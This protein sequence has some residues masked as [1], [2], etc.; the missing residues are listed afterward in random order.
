MGRWFT[1]GLS[2][3]TLYPDAEDVPAFRE[4]VR[5]AEALQSAGPVTEEARREWLVRAAERRATRWHG[6]YELAPST[7]VLHF[8]YDS[9]GREPGAR[10]LAAEL[11]RLARGFVKEPVG[12]RD[13]S[14]DA[15]ALRGSR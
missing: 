13:P 6:L 8:F 15:R 9:S 14:H 7:D 11:G 4:L 2:Y 3:G 1:I 5:A 12:R 10:P